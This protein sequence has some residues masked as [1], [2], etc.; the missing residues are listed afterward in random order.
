MTEKKRDLNLD[1]IRSLALVLV[2]GM[3]YY[4]NSGFYTISLHGGG[5][6]IMALGRMLCT[7]C[8][9]LFLLLS[10]WL[11]SCKRLSRRYYLGMLRI[12]EVY[13]ISTLACILFEAL[14]LHN[15]MSLRDMA[16]GLINFEINGYAWYVLLYGGLFLM[17]PFLNMMYAGCS[18]KNQKLILIF[19]F[20]ALS[21]L[22][23]LL[24]SFAHIYSLWWAKLYPIC[25]YF[26]GAFLREHLGRKKPGH[27]A[28]AFVLVLAA[29]CLFNQFF[30][31][32]EA[33]N[34]EGIHYEHYQVYTLSVLLFM[35]LYSLDLS[36]LPGRLS[37]LINRISELSLAAYLMSWISDGIIYR[38]F[39]PHFPIPQDRFPWIFPLVLLALL[40]SLLMAQLVHWIYKPLDSL[41]RPAL[42]RLLPEKQGR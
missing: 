29:F 2:L 1:L 6:F 27:L 38:E 17:M 28:L 7:T 14:Y 31:Q 12:L 19:S 11:C 26:T 22:P 15:F 25:Y 42:L 13:F 30:F 35:L 36:R 41:I 5:D 33:Q 18:N 9:P 8:V 10:G 24:N 4:D 21:I 16:G 34:Y 40:S 23:S 37:R 39:V 20:F 3:H 32:G